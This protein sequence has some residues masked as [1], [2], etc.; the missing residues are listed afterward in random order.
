MAILLKILAT[1]DFSTAAI[2]AL[3]TKNIVAAIIAGTFFGE[4]AVVADAL[5]VEPSS[6]GSKADAS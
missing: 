2:Q 4:N 3:P 1:G 5:Y 6:I